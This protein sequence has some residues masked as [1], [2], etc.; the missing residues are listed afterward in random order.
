M[1]QYISQLVELSKIDK[2]ID[3]FGPKI[4]QIEAK[5]KNV[6]KDKEAIEAAIAQ[7]DEDMK[8]C[9]LKKKK[10]ELHLAELSEKLEELEKK[11][12]QV[13]TEKE[14]KAIQLEEDIAKEQINFA[15][16]EIARLENICESKAEE[17]EALQERLKEIEARLVE[18]QEEVQKELEEIEK[19]REEVFKKKSELVAKIPQQILAFYEKIRRWAGN[20][21]VV[22]VKKQAC[23]GCFMKINDKTYASVIK[24]EEIT[25]CPHCGRILYL[26]EEE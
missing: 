16:D 24:G 14:L 11:R 1:K 6:Q 15:N 4:A 26:E 18:V 3:D 23:M 2:A 12:G 10:N 9:E 8:E 7:I 21:A 17:K 5:L 13:K 25:T 19:E 20:T 22:P